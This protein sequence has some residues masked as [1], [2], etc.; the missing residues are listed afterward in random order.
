[1]S[2]VP[3]NNDYYDTNFVNDDFPLEESFECWDGK[4]R[5]FEISCRQFPGYGFQVEA[6]EKGKNRMGYQFAAHDANNPYS[7]LG[8][9]RGKMNRALSRRYITHRQSGYAPLHETIEGW[10]TSDDRGLPVF[11]VNGIAL[12]YEDFLDMVEMHEGW[13]FRLRFA[14]LSEEFYALNK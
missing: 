10:L 12:T 5:L 11:V 1:M 9:L 8:I 14:E 2:E 13:Q 7:A 3:P 4:E 6:V